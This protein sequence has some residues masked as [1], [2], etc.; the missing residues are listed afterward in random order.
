MYSFDA[1]GSDLTNCST[2]RLQLRPRARRFLRAP[3]ARHAPHA[4]VTPRSSADATPMICW[5]ALLKGTA[6][7]AGRHNGLWRDREAAFDEGDSHTQT[8]FHTSCHDCALRVSNYYLADVVDMLVGAAL[9]SSMF[10]QRAFHTTTC[11]C[12]SQESPAERRGQR[13]PS[14]YVDSGSWDD[15][16]ATAG[17]AQNTWCLVHLHAQAQLIAWEIKL[18]TTHD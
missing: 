4:V 5:P 11:D 7:I 16:A 8:I 9:D 14:Q 12:R 18:L 1:F 2:R 3:I 10:V 15:F 13:A 17:R 6:L